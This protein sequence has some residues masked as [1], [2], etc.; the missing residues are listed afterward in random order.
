M[1]DI[2]CPQYEN[3]NSGYGLKKLYLIRADQ[4]SWFDRD[5][6]GLERDVPVSRKS[7]FETHSCPGLQKAV[8]VGTEGI[9]CDLPLLSAQAMREAT[10]QKQCSTMFGLF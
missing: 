8:L 4:T 10:Q 2:G 1:C 3:K 9:T 6:P 5:S 7:T